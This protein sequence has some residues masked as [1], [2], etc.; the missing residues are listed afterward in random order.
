[1][2]VFCSESTNGQASSRHS[3]STK[4]TTISVPEL[5]ALTPC[6]FGTGGCR[7]C[8]NLSAWLSSTHK[9]DPRLRSVC[10]SRMIWHSDGLPNV[11]IPM[12]TLIESV[13]CQTAGQSLPC[14]SCLE[15]VLLVAGLVVTSSSSAENS[16]WKGSGTVFCS[17]C[18]F[19]LFCCTAGRVGPDA[20]GVVFTFDVVRQGRMNG[21][22]PWAAVLSLTKRLA[23]TIHP[24]LVYT[25]TIEVKL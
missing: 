1:M 24:S 11:R 19:S 9:R 18:H 2:Q 12:D 4:S 7:E 25:I 13:E 20:S 6:T 17:L 5:E 8:A 23:I 14:G 3:P 21:A 10:S 16:S 22:R 15:A